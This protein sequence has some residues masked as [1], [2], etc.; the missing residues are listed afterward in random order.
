MSFFA[1]GTTGFTGGRAGNSM[2]KRSAAISAGRLGGCAL[3][4]G[5]LRRSMLIWVD[6]IWFATG[7]KGIDA[8]FG[9]GRLNVFGLL[10]GD[11][12]Y[13]AGFEKGVQT[14]VLAKG[15]QSKLVGSATEDNLCANFFVNVSKTAVFGKLSKAGMVRS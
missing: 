1:T 8:L 7:G 12:M 4:V 10:V 3:V 2:W 15:T 13:A 11:L 6:R 5:C 9:T 14:E